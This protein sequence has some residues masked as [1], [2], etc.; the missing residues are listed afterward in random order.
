VSPF[1]TRNVSLERRQRNGPA[2]GR[3]TSWDLPASKHLR[4]A[5]H[6]IASHDSRKP[7]GE[8]GAW[9]AKDARLGHRRQGWI[10]ANRCIKLPM[11]ITSAQLMSIATLVAGV[12]VLFMPRCLS[13][14]VAIYLIAVGLTEV[15]GIYHSVK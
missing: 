9:G 3:A 5:G 15:N 14:V 12:L 11:H 6:P 13:Y 2:R 10:D 4:Q 7:A 1:R 8:S